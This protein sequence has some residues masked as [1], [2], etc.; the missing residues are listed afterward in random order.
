MRGWMVDGTD[1]A[2]AF[3]GLVAYAR[4]WEG[5]RKM[6]SVASAASG[7]HHLKGEP[8]RAPTARLMGKIGSLSIAQASFSGSFPD[9]GA[10]RVTP[11]LPACLAPAIFRDL[12]Q[13]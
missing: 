6:A 2:D 11:Q 3:S 7:A 4:A 8:T 1:G 12:Q 13:Q 5:K 9:P 10:G